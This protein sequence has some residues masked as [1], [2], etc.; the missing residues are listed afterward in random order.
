M[1][2]AVTNRCSGL[3]YSSS[4]G[5]P[6]P[7]IPPLSSLGSLTPLSPT[8]KVR[9]RTVTKKKPTIND[10]NNNKE[11]EGD[12]ECTNTN[13]NAKS[14]WSPTSSLT[15]LTPSIGPNRTKTD[16][17]SGQYYQSATLLSQQEEV[18]LGYKVMHMVRVKSVWEELELRGMVGR[19]VEHE[20]IKLWTELA[21]YWDETPGQASSH[22]S[23]ED[24]AQL[25]PCNAQYSSGPGALR[26]GK[27]RRKKGK[28]DLAEEFGNRKGS[29]ADFERIMRE[30]MEARQR[31]IESNMRLVI[32]IA[33]KY[34]IYGVGQQDLVQEGSL[35]LMRACEKFDP[36]LGYKFSTYASW[37]IQQAV[38]L[39]IAYQSRTIRLPVHIHNLMGKIKKTKGE[40]LGEG[41]KVTEEEVA[42]RV[43]LT[44]VKLSEITKLTR[45]SISLDLLK[46]GNNPGDTNPLSILDTLEQKLDAQ[47][48]GTTGEGSIDRAFLREDLNK[49][50]SVLDDEESMVIKLRYGMLDGKFRAVSEVAV[51]LGREKGWV[52]GQECRAL[53][54]LRRPWYEEK[55]KQHQDA[56]DEI[57]DE[58]SETERDR[59]M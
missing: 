30:G 48:E 49:M 11:G 40:I 37:W 20:H 27:R 24:L 13:A 32:S 2:I 22:S 14:E 44:S 43:G 19:P 15:N 45:K 17:N 31:M 29:V 5:A 34:V 41:G 47:G 26:D 23:W 58:G 50:M 6:R 42:R 51:V 53:R 46:Y 35:G 52:R 18:E 10:I 28:V 8:K 25:V 16:I 56:I 1:I 3:G 54:K 59:I 33:R 7:P 9:M 57:E 36:A 55:L 38:F 12:G 21:G 4:I 39:C